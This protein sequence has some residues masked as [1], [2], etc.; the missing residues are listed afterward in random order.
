MGSWSSVGIVLWC[1]ARPAVG[2]RGPGTRLLEQSRPGGLLN[3][4]C[5]RS[6]G[7]GGEDSEPPTQG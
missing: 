1:P 3:L 4:T 5:A 7:E 2:S 6:G